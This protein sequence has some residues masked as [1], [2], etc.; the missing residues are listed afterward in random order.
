ML[1]RIGSMVAPFIATG[2][3]QFGHEIPPLIFGIVPILGAILVL[4]LPE[5]KGQQLPE[6]IEDAENFGKKQKSLA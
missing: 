3:S 2:L 6:T 5:T 1:A 4:Y